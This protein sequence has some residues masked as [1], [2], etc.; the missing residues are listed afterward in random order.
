[1]NEEVPKKSRGKTDE[2]RL[3]DV[4][5]ELHLSRQQVQKVIQ[6][7]K[8]EGNTVPF[9]SRYRKNETDNLSEEA[10]RSIIERWDY[11]FHLDKR[12]EEILNTLWKREQLTAELKR[13]VLA[14]ENMQELEEL[15]K[16]YKQKKKTRGMK[17]KD[18]G[19]LNLAHRIK[20]G[21]IETR[22][23]ALELAQQFVD[24]EKGV[25]NVEVALQGACDILA[26]QVAEKMENR[27]KARQIVSPEVVL[28]SELKNQ[29]KDE[30]GVYE[31]Y[32]DYQEKLANMPYHRLMAL[33]R[34]E[35]EGI[36]K[37]TYQSPE[38][39]VVDGI[40]VQETHAVNKNY[41][42]E[43]V[44]RAVE[45]ACKRLI[46]PAVERALR[47]AQS[48][49][50]EERA[51][52]IFAHNLERLLMQPP[53][54]GKVIMGIDPAYRS[55]CK[56]AVIDPRG[57]MLAVDVIYPTPPFNQVASAREKLAK[58][59]NTLQVEI[60]AIGN[61]T[62]SRETEEFISAAIGD[63]NLNIQYA[64]VS[65]D[66]ASVYSASRLAGEEYPQL[67]VQERSAISIARRVLDPLAELVKIDPKS[68]GVGQYQ[69]DVPQGKLREAVQFV[70]EKVVN[71]VGVDVNTASVYLLQY[72]SGLNKTRAENIVNTRW[73][74]GSFRDREQL[75]KV[76]GL[77]PKSFE[78]SAGFLRILNGQ[79]PLDRTAI[80]PESYR[81][82][83][84]VLEHWD[85]SIF[86][87]GTSDLREMAAAML[88]DACAF[89][90][91]LVKIG[92]DSY[93]LKD[94]LEAFK[95]P[96]Y[97]P[98]DEFQKPKLK[99]EVINI[100]DLKEGMM[101]EG[102]VRNV[103]D[104]GAFIDLGLKHDG[105][106]HISNLSD[107]FVKHPMEE[108]S[109]GDVVKVEVLNIDISRGR[110]GLKKIQ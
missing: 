6:L 87:I 51:I 41:A 104:F 58:Y 86:D 29:Q 97:D 42:R 2:E 32:Y 100:E 8:E 16:P 50:A 45:D 47:A 91:Q 5:T 74:L 62:A 12:K 38:K 103:V 1:M 99:K 25:E 22:E 94:F 60:V 49:A 24:S 77:G 11:L 108:V 37:I 57:D 27:R 82:A 15:Y 61:G 65:E 13:A 75:K 98:R 20:E 70:V 96:L 102:E 23:E 43:M 88:K 72:I 46:I 53:I 36:L 80:H 83:E 48:E 67:D 93:T 81:L 21:K 34:G 9:V 68:V 107:R 109:V 3:T 7:I 84:A 26:E 14:A 17:A 56:L 110:I 39:H 19:L 55:G 63:L 10:I 101:L 66:G 106:I 78:Q 79:N 69:H 35:K 85:K 52:N 105:L 54:K 90:D 73:E 31:D 28:K 95:K 89:Q 44:E 59:I 30:E 64:I 71:Q 40:A 4:K 18:R 92:T 33:N 76:K